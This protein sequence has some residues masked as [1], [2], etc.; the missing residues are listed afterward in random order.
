[1]SNDHIC[2][3]CTKTCKSI[4][5]LRIHKLEKHY[6]PNSNMIQCTCCLNMFRSVRFDYKKGKHAYDKCEE[7]RELQVKLQTNHLVHGTFVYGVGK[8]RFFI[9]KGKAIRACALHTCDNLFPCDHHVNQQNFVQCRGTKCNNCYEQNGFNFCEKCRDKNDKS[10]NKLRNKV[11]EFK[12]ELGG[13]CVDCGLDQLFFL[14]FDHID[15]T[16]KNIQITRSVPSAWNAEKNNIELRCGRCHRI[17]TAKNQ[18][19]FSKNEKQ[20]RCKEDKK[21]FVK[22]V[23]K[24]IDRCQLCQWTFSDKD[25]M[26]ATLDFDHVT[27]DKLNQISRLYTNN[28]NRIANE[29][30]KTRLLCRHCHEIHTC[31]QRGGKKMLFYFTE[32]EIQ[33]FKDRLNCQVT[34]Q[35]HQ[36]EI[37]QALKSLEF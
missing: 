35:Q 30:R 6:K 5:S 25:K 2:N 17:K 22:D 34:I 27:N 13:K 24:L 16:K 31:L 32:Q 12:Q 26:C 4:A 7:C 11:K 28:R 33:N 18:K 36:E 15:P 21:T 20:F 29:I 9:D 14:E 8:E 23:K 37:D 1:M 3:I 10:K 19:P